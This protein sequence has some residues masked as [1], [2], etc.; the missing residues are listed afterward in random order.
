M[1]DKLSPRKSRAMFDQLRAVSI[2]V[3]GARWIFSSI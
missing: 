1:L 2:S 3:R